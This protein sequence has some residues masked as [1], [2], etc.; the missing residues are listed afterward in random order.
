MGLTQRSSAVHV[1]REPL[2]GSLG[3]FG[4]SEL[5]NTLAFTSGTFVQDFGEG[6]GSDSLE[7]LHEIFVRSGPGQLWCFSRFHNR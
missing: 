3:L 1:P 6:D 7:K 5:N 4:L 2:S